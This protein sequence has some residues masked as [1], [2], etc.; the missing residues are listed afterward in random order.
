[1]LWSPELS[2][3]ARFMVWKFWPKAGMG[4][5]IAPPAPSAPPPLEWGGVGNFSDY[6]D[7]S[8]VVQAPGCVAHQAHR[9][10]SLPARHGRPRLDRRPQRLERPARKLGVGPADGIED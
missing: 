2:G 9:P 5:G 10:V 6:G 4:S 1:M 8:L 7:V 3:R